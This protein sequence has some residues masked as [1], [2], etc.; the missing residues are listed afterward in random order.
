MALAVPLGVVEV[1][2][3]GIWRDGPRG[4]V[5]RALVVHTG[6]EDSR[7]AK[8]FLQWVLEGDDGRYTGI[9]ANVGISEFNDRALPEVSVALDG[10]GEN[11]ARLTLEAPEAAD[12]ALRRMVVLAARPGKYVVVPAPANAGR[13][14]DTGTVGQN[15]S[16][17]LEKAGPQERSAPASAHADVQPAA[18]GAPRAS[19]PAPPAAPR[20]RRKIRK[21]SKAN[22]ARPAP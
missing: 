2:I 18:R 20:A 10:A 17:S 11:V 3:G 12:P 15:P 8:V 13:E 21:R 7:A 14:G 16:S 1:A 19:E 6:G 5:Y 22:T 9:A 4:G